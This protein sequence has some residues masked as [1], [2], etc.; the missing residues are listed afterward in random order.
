MKHF[1]ENEKCTQLKKDAAWKPLIRLFRRY[2]KNDAL[3]KATC[4]RIQDA[5][6][7]KQGQLLC[8]ALEVPRELARKPRTQL[9]V[10]MMVK[11]H[12]IICKKQLTPGVKRVMGRHATDIWDNYYEIFNENSLVQRRQFFSDP[13]V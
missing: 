4:D 6:I 8:E 9:A 13:L 12:R 3:S 10:L 11:S 1:Q 7:G 2:L 5:P